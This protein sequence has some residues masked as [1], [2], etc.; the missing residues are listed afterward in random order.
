VAVEVALAVDRPDDRRDRDDL[1]TEAPLADETE[2]VDHLLVRQDHLDVARLEPQPCGESGEDRSAARAKSGRT[3][4]VRLR[5]EPMRQAADWLRRYERFWSASLDRLAA[6]AEAK[7]V[8]LR[9][10]VKEGRQ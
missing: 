3:V 7:E 10:K 1:E 9:A 8:A 5:P 4:T 6:Y 2:R